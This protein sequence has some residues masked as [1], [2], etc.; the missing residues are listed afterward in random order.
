M[1]AKD[2]GRDGIMATSWRVTQGH[3]VAIFIVYVT[4]LKKASALIIPVNPH[5]NPRRG[6]VFMHPFYS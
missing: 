3:L 4:V 5:N 6:I 2:K 1:C